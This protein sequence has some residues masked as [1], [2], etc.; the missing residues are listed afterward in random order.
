MKPKPFTYMRA[1]GVDEA[2]DALARLRDDARILAGGQSLVAMMNFRLV[3][4]KAIIDIS[5][6][7]PLAYIREGNG[8]IE[9]GAST[10]QAQVMDWPKL[11]Q[12]VP[13]L[14]LALP[15]VGH[16]Q[17]RSRGTVCGSIAHSD[18]SSELPLCLATLGGRVVLRSSAGER[19][20]TAGEFQTGMMATA[21]R[22]D[23]IITAVHIPMRQP[24]AGYAF[25][26]LTQRH[27]D[28]AICAVAAVASGKTIR[29]GVGGVADKPAIRDWPAL[30]AG[31]ID[32]ALNDFA[33]DL[34][35]SDDI[36]ASAAYRREMV[37]RLGRRVI[38]EA[39]RCSN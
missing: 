24:G 35:G 1:A 17:T 7:A 4:A 9:I 13:L 29:L 27:G 14:S 10:T 37:R 22:P 31:E 25:T 3:E 21:R 12:V 11:A 15:H 28:F 26:E 33:W 5:G 36:H 34:G 39:Q 32:D 23:E 18:P 38:E 16:F 8:E 6:L 20:L 19:V 2:V 30:A